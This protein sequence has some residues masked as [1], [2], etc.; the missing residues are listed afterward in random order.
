MAEKPDPLVS[1]DPNGKAALISYDV[2]EPTSYAGKNFIELVFDA[3]YFK[4]DFRNND[5]LPAQPSNDA[6]LRALR[7]AIATQSPHTARAP[8]GVS[9]AGGTA[10]I[11]RS[12]GLGALPPSVPS[13]EPLSPK[14]AKTDLAELERA[15]KAGNTLHVYRSMSGALTYK[16]TRTPDQR[17]PRLL[18]V[19]E[20]RLTTF[21]AR[22]GA[23]KTLKTYSLFPGEKTRISVRSYLKRETEALSASSI[24]ESATQES[25]EDFESTVESEQTSQSKYEESF[26]YH[27][28]GSVS[29]TW[30]WGSAKVAGGV[31]GGTAG[32]REEFAKNVSNATSKH[33]AKAS[34][35]RDV[36]INTSYKAREES[37]EETSIE[38]QI[39]NI[40][41]SR[42]LNFVFRQMNQEFITLLHLVDVRVAFFDGSADS[43]REVSL[44][45]LDDL[46]S[47]VIN[48]PAKR[49]EVRASIVEQL[50]HVFDYQDATH[51]VIEQAAF[52]DG[53]GV[54][55]PNS[56]YL[57]FRRNLVSVYTDPID[58]ATFSVP[59]VIVSATKSVLRTE[60]IIVE[61][62]LGQA[63]ALDSYATDLQLAEV[64]RRQAEALRSEAEARRETIINGLAKDG[65]AAG[66]TILAQLTCPCDHGN[67]L[68]PE[69]DGR[70]PAPLAP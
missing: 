54:A 45:Q 16:V 10:M 70:R 35:K 38:R 65:N 41:R 30:G 36:Q 51:S 46:L 3:S 14:L 9:G 53:Q 6:G 33:A 18:L 61:A 2:P 19:E 21:A 25:S 5:S 47:E 43:R 4:K 60:G 67:F 15:I 27:V 32:A 52:V 50:D 20:Y 8:G 22:Y 44:S 49:V 64:R 12:L 13:N 55:I 58:H 1:L 62:L 66:A 63:P 59:G 68:Q 48:T 69:N 57:R 26:N 11:G 24:L 7:A 39:E 23:G 37:G 34:A 42:T 28:E 17:R 31:K 56:D 40:N 29:A